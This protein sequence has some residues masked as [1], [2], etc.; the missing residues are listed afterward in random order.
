MSSIARRGFVASCLAM[1]A[2]MACSPAAL[3]GGASLDMSPLEAA[4]TG[5]TDRLIIKYKAG[6]PAAARAEAQRMALAHEAVQRAGVQMQYLRSTA[7]GAHVMKLDRLLSVREVRALARAVADVDTDVEYVEPDRRMVP[8]FTPN[9]TSYNLQWHYHEATGG[10][11]APSAW[12]KSTGTGVRVAVI[13]TGYRPHADL[14]ANIVGGYDFIADTFVANDGNGR[15]ASALDPGDWIAANECGGSHAAQNSSWHGTH[16]AGTVAAVTN[17]ASGVAGVAFGAK[18]VPVR[19]L[20]KCG[21]YTSDIADA[22][23]WAAGGTVSGVSAN[24]Y[25]AKVLNL[26]LGGSG[27]CDSTTQSAINDAR[28]RGAV[29]V[30]A[31]GNSNANAANY[32]PASCAGVITVAATGRSG[33]RAYY[34]NYGSVVDLAGPGGDM[35]GSSANGVYST[36]NTGTSSPGS[37]TY[38]YY[39]G[40]SMAAPHVAA[41][42]A[43]MFAK[44]GALTPDQVESML[45]STA[46]AFPGTCSQCG[47]GIVNASAAV[48]AAGGGGGGGTNV[49]EV[50]SN[51]TL[52]TAQSVTANPATVSGTIGSTSDTDYFK[53]T[54]GAGKTLTSTL[55]PNASSDYDLYLYNAS[56][57]Q[58]ASSVK[59]TGQVDSIVRT[60]TGTGA[61]TWYVRVR[62]YSGSTGSSGTYT[63]GLSQ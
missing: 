39:Q 22:I 35:S 13:D 44:N 61:V 16:V 10:L 31:A 19:V 42:A 37:D 62:Y 50:E 8:L 9:D 20:G 58:L 7:A 14:A 57:T 55:T 53:V 60:N 23:R 25:P 30:V 43:L 47:S 48:D 27:S 63:L 29:V 36:L 33:S 59:G 1:A 34:S 24:A 5:H 4:I 21:G 40:T 54:V 52:A 45:K 32:S 51:N 26:S 56:G 28:S 17:N 11:N 18:V 46:R 6:T 49:P 15:D 12:D 3:A 2:A 41:V 38:A